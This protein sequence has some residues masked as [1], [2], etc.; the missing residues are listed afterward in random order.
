MTENHD[1]PTHGGPAPTDSLAEPTVSKVWLALRAIQVRL[2]FIAVLVLAFV[3]VGQW[4]TLRNYW[5]RVTSLARDSGRGFQTVSNDTEYFCPMDPGVV[6]DWPSKCGICNMA[7]VRRKKGEATPLPSGVVAR[8]QFS[9]YRVQLA[10]IQVLPAS[11]QAL[12]REVVLSGSVV[13]QKPCTIEAE[14]FDRDRP[15]VVAGQKAE[16]SAEGWESSRSLNGKVREILV[17]DSDGHHPARVC[18]EI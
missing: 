9:P 12:A 1:Q 11:Y 18:L 2:R 5:D 4:E 16:V 8:M 15:L 6:T 7:L 3:I 13:G 14:L 17:A 10:G